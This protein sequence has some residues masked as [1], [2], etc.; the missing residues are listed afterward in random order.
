LPQSC[1][2]SLRCPVLERDR[3]AR[4][5][6]VH[7]ALQLAGR[8][9]TLS[10]LRSW[11][12][13]PHL[14]GTW[15]P[16]RMSSPRVH[17]ND[18][19]VV[20]GIRTNPERFC[21]DPDRTHTA[22]RLGLCRHRGAVACRSSP[23]SKV[24]VVLALFGFTLPVSFAVLP[25]TLSAITRGG[26]G[27]GSRKERRVH[28]QPALPAMFVPNRPEVVQGIGHKTCYPAS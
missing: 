2:R 25:V 10:A 14:S 26:N 22:D 21:T 19:I 28:T 9:V 24:T 8:P 12:A 18:A 11:Q 4:V 5:V 17:R 20:D 13:V 6:R 27:R 3:C 1:Y 7:T 23:Y 15:N 16:H